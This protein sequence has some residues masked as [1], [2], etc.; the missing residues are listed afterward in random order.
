MDVCRIYMVTMLV[1]VQSRRSA[2]GDFQSARLQRSYWLHP[3]NICSIE[4]ENQVHLTGR[5]L[6]RIV[7]D[8]RHVKDSRHLNA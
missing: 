5:E 8:Q 7:P 6:G 4:Q 3:C 2:V 1:F